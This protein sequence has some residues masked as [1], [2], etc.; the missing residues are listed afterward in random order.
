[1]ASD[2][3]APEIFELGRR[4]LGVAHGV[5]DVFVPKVVLDCSGIVT[6]ACQLVAGSVAQHVRMHLER[7][8][9]LQRLKHW[10][11]PPV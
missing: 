7:K 11:K 3:G 8:A 9:R 4:Q 10:P 1:M 5:L 2:L 6:I